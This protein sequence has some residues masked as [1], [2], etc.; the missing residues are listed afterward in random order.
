MARAARPFETRLVIWT[1]A[2]ALPSLAGF[3]VLL[4]L[5]R[6]AGPAW[7]ALAL[8]CG[9]L[10]AIALMLRHRFSYSLRTLTNLLESLREGSYT[11]RGTQ[12]HGR[13][14]LGEATGKINALADALQAE[15]VASQEAGALL[16]KV[17]DEI[18][19]A[20]LTFDQLE[21]LTFV[22]PAGARLLGEDRRA[23]IGRPAAALS[24]STLL[25]G[26]AATPLRQTFASGEGPWDVHRRVFR[27]EGE[28]RYLL[29]ITDLSRALR[30]EERRAWHQLI[31]VLGHE[32]NNSLAPIRSTASTLARVL[33]KDPLPADWRDDVSEGMSIVGK[34]ADSLSRFMRAYTSLAKLP[35]PR[36]RATRLGALIERA[37]KLDPR[38]TVDVQRGTPMTLQIDT[39]LVEQA[40]INLIKNAIDAAGPGAV[41]LTWH[42]TRD[43]AVI[44]IY[45][46]GP[47][48]AGTDNL[49]VPFY[50]TKP[51][52][53]GIGLVIARQIAEAHGGQLVL[54]N[55][56]DRSGCVA[57]LRLPR[58]GGAQE[59]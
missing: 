54:E 48:L 30:E 13:G 46:E 22:N 4:W 3:A 43:E 37:A 32:I 47:G 7:I 28:R 34:R 39:D 33:R 27:Q 49:F 55:R 35:T 25:R 51:E 42:A 19:M 31:R 24:L 12:A 57:R 26:P 14:V 52:G 20:V 8:A 17:V 36:V 6:T 1:V 9:W 23:L 59:Q 11:L 45:D 50:T 10:L 41:S 18:D 5:D 58:R 44:E 38:K 15:R 56:Q 40:L 2:A 21:R 16:G 29:V 53:T